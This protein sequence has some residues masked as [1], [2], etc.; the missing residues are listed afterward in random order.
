VTKKEKIIVFLPLGG[1]LAYVVYLAFLSPKPFLLRWVEGCFGLFVAL[2][3]CNLLRRSAVAR[4]E[5]EE[6]ED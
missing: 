2:V 5:R 4:S 6:G 1:F 3:F